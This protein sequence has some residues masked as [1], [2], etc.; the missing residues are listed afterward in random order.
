MFGEVPTELPQHFVFVLL[1]QFSMLP[2]ISAVDPLR[3]ANRFAEQDLYSWQ[4]AYAGDGPVSASNGLTLGPQ[5]PLKDVPETVT[6]IVCSGLEPRREIPKALIPGLRKRAR[7]GADIG[8]LCTGAHILGMAGILDGYT[9]TIHWENRLAFEEEFPQTA[10]TEHLFEIDRNRFTCA[11]GAAA[12]DMMLALITE[13]H[14]VEIAS[15]VAEQIIHSPVRS[16]TEGQRPSRAARIGMRH[17]RLSGVLKAMDA[18][19]ED[20]VSPSR[21][22]ADA[23]LSTRQLER[24]F[25]RYIGR[26]PKRYFLE[27]RLKRARYLLLQTDMPVVDVAVACGFTTTSHFSKC[28]RGFF[29]TTPHRERGLPE[30]AGAAHT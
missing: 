17:P 24:L 25:R 16:Q 14:G 27:L 12:M 2:V 13:Q 15:E 1:E 30:R 6:L 5:V 7:R 18:S 21:L 29:G 22:A 23:G 19:M 8:A 3:L 11:G 28:Y 4:M 26:S 10:I 20:P 9:C